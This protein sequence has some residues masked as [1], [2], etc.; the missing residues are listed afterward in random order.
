MECGGRDQRKNR[1]RRHEDG[2]EEKTAVTRSGNAAMPIGV[3]RPD[4]PGWTQW[5]AVS[6]RPA[7]RPEGSQEPPN[8]G[9]IERRP[10]DWA[11]YRAPTKQ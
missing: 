11:M 1:Q 6:P 10:D 3:K 8:G 7:D 4:W 2:G 9:K 5:P